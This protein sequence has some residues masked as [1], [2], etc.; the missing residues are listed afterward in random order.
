MSLQILK[1]L[2]IVTLFMVIT[3]KTTQ[4][5]LMLTKTVE[6]GILTRSGTDEYD[7]DAK[8]RIL[9]ILTQL[10]LM[11]VSMLMVEFILI[12]ML[13]LNDADDNCC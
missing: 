4:K 7:H 6:I 11:T 12:W 9:M 5:T 13:M 8:L 10:M 1:M 3:I 2:R